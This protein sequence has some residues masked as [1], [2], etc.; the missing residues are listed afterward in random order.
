[1]ARITA[2]DLLMKRLIYKSRL[3]LQWL[4]EEHRRMN[5]H[6]LLQVRYHELSAVLRTNFLEQENA[7]RQR[8]G[9]MTNC[10]FR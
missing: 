7:A 10:L 3:R 2:R 9:P 6:L 8:Q 1:M 5:R 4:D